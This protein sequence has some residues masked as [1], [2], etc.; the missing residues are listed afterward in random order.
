M[1]RTATGAILTAVLLAIQT[2][3]VQT[4]INKYVPQAA[5]Q[6]GLKQSAVPDL[7]A[8]VAMGTPQA[9]AKV[10]GITAATEAAVAQALTSAYAYAYQFVYYAAAAFCSVGLIAC[11]ALRDHDHLFN[12]HLPRQIYKADAA[13]PKQLN[14]DDLSAGDI[15]DLE[16]SRTEK[17]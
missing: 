12:D 14:E 6:A 3:K 11:I 16:K 5:V 4:G 10:P 17:A 13:V 2:S 15:K 1:V 8:A 7:L 9:L